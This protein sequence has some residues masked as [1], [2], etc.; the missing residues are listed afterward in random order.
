MNKMWGAVGLGWG[1]AV[2]E[3][4]IRVEGLGGGKQAVCKGGGNLDKNQNRATKAQFWQT[5]CGRCS[6]QIGRVWMERGT[7]GLRGWEVVSEW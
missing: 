1:D 6:I 7:L 5:K 2:E 3:G 4:Y